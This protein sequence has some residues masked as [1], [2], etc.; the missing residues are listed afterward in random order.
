VS[1][2][3]ARLLAGP[4]PAS[5]PLGLSV[6]VG[7]VVNNKDTEGLGRV[8]V[9]FEWLSDL[10]ESAWARIAAPTA[11]KDRGMYFLPEIDDEV[12]VAFAHGDVRFPY[13]IGCL[14]NGVD[15]PPAD[16]ADGANNI[17]VLKSRSGHV[18]RLDD[19]QGKEKIEIVDA[20][21]GNRIVIDTATNDVRITAK[22]DITLSAP[23][24]TIKLAAK[25]I[26]LDASG[27]ALITGGGRVSVAA[28]ED[29]DVAG[30]TINLN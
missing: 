12:L 26:D 29:V 15:A 16:N 20:N 28:D 8:K 23:D 7:R 4:A 9:K 11:G 17:R 10:N 30:R 14:W 2:D 18:I 22:G 6:V 13:V 3:L 1:A 25:S 21:G 5:L 27:D 24:G 19:T